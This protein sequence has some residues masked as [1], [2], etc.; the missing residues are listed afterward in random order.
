MLLRDPV[1]GLIA[2]EG[3]A[4]KVI[5]ELL[6]CRE[7][8]RLRRVKQ[9]GLTSLV[10][11]GAEHT[12]FSHALGTAHV[13][14][15]LQRRIRS[16]HQA[17]PVEARMDDQSADDALAAALL[18]DLGHGPFSHLY[19]EVAEN[20]RHHEA[21]TKDALLDPGTDVHRALEGLSSGMASRVADMLSGEHRL[22]Y[23]GRA[24]SGALDVD[25]A[26]YLLRDSYMTGVRYGL[27]DLEWVLAAFTFGEVAGHWVLAV[28]GRK[29]LPP[30]ESFFVARQNMYSQVYH[31]KATRA[32]EAI[33]RA[34]FTRAG[35]LIREGNPPSRT[36]QALVSAARDQPVS[37]N[38]YLALD[39]VQLL[40]AFAEWENA[41]DPILADLARRLR[42]RALPKTLPL[43]PE[44]PR[45]WEEAQ[46]RA[47]EVAT[48]HGLRADLSVYVDETS[49][50]PY[51]EP[52][53]ADPSPRGLWVKI[54]HRP[55]ERL[56]EASFLLRELR[57]KR[58]QRPR[59]IFPAELRDE[60]E[61][62]VAPIL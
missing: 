13:M 35:E 34:L 7:V 19:E 36:P 41:Y 18:H 42:A 8:Q 49:D 29:G 44:T 5:T 4:E 23:L 14:Q 28:E 40:S 52:D 2:F 32:A 16:Q 45:V 3:R 53:A 46:A 11:P 10:F 25:R 39:D 37:I 15:L 48:R 1:H 51:P 30:I 54:R 22:G 47:S 33:I 61:A 26:D 27:F 38:D 12:R 56:G 50:V 59:L 62:A 31:H 6:R 21:W 57:N 24:V 43:P 55:I 9:L 60:I 58:I 20:P 17:L